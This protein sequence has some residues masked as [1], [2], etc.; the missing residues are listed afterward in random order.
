MCGNG[1][2]AK[3]DGVA[4]KGI[5]NRRRPA[6]TGPEVRCPLRSQFVRLV[7]V[8]R[9]G[10]AL[11]SRRN[12]KIV[13]KARFSPAKTRRLTKT[14]QRIGI[15]LADEIDVKFSDN[16]KLPPISIDYLNDYCFRRLAKRKSAQIAPCS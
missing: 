16:P 3:R 1:S 7:R 5:R 15:N 4:F 10:R 11:P 8:V 2:G 6:V 14:R 12:K 9:Q 13:K